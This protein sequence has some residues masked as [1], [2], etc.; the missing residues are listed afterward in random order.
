M[1]DRYFLGID[2]GGTKTSVLCVDEQSRVVG[3]GL[4]GPTNLTSTSVGAASLSLREGI[5][6]AIENLPPEAELVRVV[7]GLAGLDSE[8]EHESAVKIFREVTQHF[9]IGE[10]SLLNDSEI[11]LANGSER[12]DA[13]ILLSGT[14]A[15]CV[16]RNQA[17]VRAQAGG[18]DFL[19]SDQG[20]GY[21]IGRRVLL[22]AVKSF[23]GRGPLTQ[24]EAL[25]CHHFEV[26]SVAKLKQPIYQPILTK[27]E[28]AALSTLCLTAAREGDE[29]SRLILD[30]IVEELVAYVRAVAGRLTLLAKSFDL[31]LAGSIALDDYILERL[32]PALMALAPEAKL[33]IPDRPPVWGAIKLA[34]AQ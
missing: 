26:N 31:V 32:R 33:I 13:L 8:A 24:L 27:P 14:G 28:V 12:A 9:R 17:G 1:S 15:N 16:G 11:A 19:L 7:M 4:S 10:L 29:V 22:A 6:Q 5:R 21:D 18:K 25:V 3:E 20:S 2:G 30:A 34:L 23:D